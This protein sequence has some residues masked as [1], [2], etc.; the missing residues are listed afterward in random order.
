MKDPYNVQPVE[1][2]NQMIE[3]Q[4]EGLGLSAEMYKKCLHCGKMFRPVSP[5]HYYCCAACGIKYRA[6]TDLK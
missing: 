5:R 4:M 6:H 2:Y 3:A 1:Q